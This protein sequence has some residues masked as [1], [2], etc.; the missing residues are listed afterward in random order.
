MNL[1]VVAPNKSILW[2]ARMLASQRPPTHGPFGWE[3]YVRRHPELRVRG[4]AGY[5]VDLDAPLEREWCADQL[6]HLVPMAE[7]P[8]G[9]A[10]PKGP[11]KIDLPAALAEI[12]E[13]KS[14]QRERADVA[15]FAVQKA[16][17]GGAAWEDKA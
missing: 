5:V 3:R 12:E 8:A 14:R 16:A 13:F 1:H 6:A 9:V 10:Q 11:T 17:A 2:P 4:G 7:L 15:A